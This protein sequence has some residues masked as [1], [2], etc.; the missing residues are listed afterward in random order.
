MVAL[1]CAGLSLVG[2]ALVARLL[3]VVQHHYQG[4]LLLLLRPPTPRL[5][6][7]FLLLLLS[8]QRCIHRAGAEHGE[9]S[10]AAIWV[11]Q[12]ETM[13]VINKRLKCCTCDFYTCEDVFSYSCF[14]QL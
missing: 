11:N 9:V 6:P 2:E 8:G 12:P 14:I 13:C 4:L 5:L 10:Q 3:G 1:L 7:I